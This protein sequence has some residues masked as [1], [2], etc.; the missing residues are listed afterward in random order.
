MRT[1]VRIL[2]F[3]FF[4]FWFLSPGARLLLFTHS[5]SAYLHVFDI[6]SRSSHLSVFIKTEDFSK[7]TC[8]VSEEVIPQPKSEKEQTNFHPVHRQKI[9]FFSEH[10]HGKIKSQSVFHVEVEKSF[11]V[12]F[13]N[14]KKNVRSKLEN[15]LIGGMELTPQKYARRYN[16]N[17]MKSYRWSPAVRLT[18]LLEFK[19]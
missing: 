9:V 16:R 11:E 5:L 19:S 10:F 18:D 1:V 13:L 6:F 15:R 17:H 7:K 3:Y 4:T 8:Y 12:S 14:E 2:L